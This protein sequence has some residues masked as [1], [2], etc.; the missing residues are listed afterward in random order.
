MSDRAHSPAHVVAIDIGGSNTK[1]ALVSS[2]G[3]RLETLRQLPTP[4]RGDPEAFLSALVDQVKGLCGRSEPVCGA[5]IALP[6]FLSDDL[7]TVIYNP[8]TPMLV[9]YPL[10]SR[11]TQALGLPV[12]LEIDCNAAA[13]G[14]YRFGAGRSVRRLL[15][16][17]L[18]TG[19]GGGMLVDGQPLRFTAGCCGDIG[20]AYVG[21]EERCSAGCKGC[22]EAMVSVEAL[23]RA[24]ARAWGDGR[25]GAVMAV[26]TLIE[27]ASAGEEKSAAI[28][29]EAGRHIGVAVASL[30]S[31]FR[32]D[33]VLLAGG[34][35]EA[36]DLLTV[37]ANEAFQHYA[38]SYFH[39]PI[40]K[41][42]LGSSAGLA[43]AAV[44]LLP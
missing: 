39:A 21:G 31:F 17:S 8:N 5:G 13:L 42:A 28:L 3:P 26:R 2:E 41:A 37:P 29:R 12:T 16:L 22:L 32:P 4:S 24:V 44:A 10:R 18:G 38:A 40:R 15:V 34:I 27:A 9:D 23:S 43:G 20:H 1:I 11:M 19:V 7:E 6:G 14:E 30:S 36:G 33:L 35:S 25:N